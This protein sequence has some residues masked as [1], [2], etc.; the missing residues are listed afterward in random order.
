MGEAREAVERYYQAFDGK[1]PVWKEMITPDV[2]FTGLLQQ[3]ANA[4]EFVQLTEQFLQFHKAT[5]VRARFEEGDRVCSILELDLAT[6]AGDELTCLISEL[7]T[8]RGGKLANVEVVYDPR[9]IADA[10]G[11]S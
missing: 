5:R 8:V 10:Y 3:A 6:P 7:T 1:D 4:D 9:K 2:R 11:L